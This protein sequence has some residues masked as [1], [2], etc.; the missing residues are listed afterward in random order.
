MQIV[1]SI[2]TRKL[3][4]VSEEEIEAM[5]LISEFR[6][7]LL[8]PA[9][10]PDRP[11]PPPPA[12]TAP[13]APAHTRPFGLPPQKWTP[14]PAAKRNKVCAVCGAPFTDASRQNTCK[15]CDRA[16]CKRELRRLSKAQKPDAARIAPA[17]KRARKINGM[18]PDEFREKRLAMIKAATEKAN[19][20]QLTR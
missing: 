9:N 8:P 19:A 5:K 2:D 7:L 13:P 18:T 12:P 15:V 11:A 17:A 4:L 14:R 6:A 3:V 1:G 10:A 16:E 20:A